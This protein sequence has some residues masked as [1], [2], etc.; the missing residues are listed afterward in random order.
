MWPTTM[1]RDGVAVELDARGPTVRVAGQSVWRIRHWLRTLR[2]ADVPRTTPGELISCTTASAGAMA[3]AVARGVAVALSDG[4]YTLPEGPAR[5]APA[6]VDPLLA[7]PST[8]A[9]A[10]LALLMALRPYSTHQAWA[11]ALGVTRGRVT[12]ILAT[13]DSVDA[14]ALVDRWLAGEPHTTGLAVY[15]YSDADAWQ[16]AAHLC[17]HLDAGLEP[18]EPR[19]IIGGELAADVHAP[20]TN[21]QRAVVRARRI[22]GVPPEFVVADAPETATAVVLLDT[23]P[24]PRALARPTPTPVGDRLLAHPATALADIA[25]LTPDDRRRREQQAELITVLRHAAT[26]QP[27]A[28]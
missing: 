25:A 9:D 14:D 21:P 27:Q 19:A 10:R 28:T 8:P 22:D 20:W 1:A 2:P 6:A 26:P 11:D 13:L 7:R 16:Q 24:L 3:R 17:A 5:Q 15:L 4:R 23:D 18:D 12:Q